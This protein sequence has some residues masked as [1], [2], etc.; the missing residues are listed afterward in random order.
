MGWLGVEGW[1]M[2]DIY[3]GH[4]SCLSITNI[5]VMLQQRSFC[6]CEIMENALHVM[7]KNIHAKLLYWFLVWLC[8]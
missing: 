7:V 1:Q 2:V 4:T 5:F 6:Q 3:D 8:K